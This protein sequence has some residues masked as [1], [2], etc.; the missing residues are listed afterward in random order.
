MAE[1]IAQIDEKKEAGAIYTSSTGI[2]V[3]VTIDGLRPNGLA[4][5][6]RERDANHLKKPH[7]LAREAVNCN[8][9]WEALAIQCMSELASLRQVAIMINQDSTSEFIKVY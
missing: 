3:A 6:C 9:D 2:A 5:S 1:L 4:F 8:A 7:D